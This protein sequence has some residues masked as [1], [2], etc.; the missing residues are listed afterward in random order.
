MSSLR[1]IR[2]C[3]AQDREVYLGSIDG[4]S[5]RFNSGQCTQF[6]YQ[7]LNTCGKVCARA[8]PCKA[9]Q[10]SGIVAHA[11]SP[12]LNVTREAN[13]V[14]CVCPG[15]DT[16]SRR[17]PASDADHPAHRGLCA[18]VAFWR[19]AARSATRRTVLRP[20]RAL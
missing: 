19:C 6:G 10:T 9:P 7:S 11:L 18:I 13:F 17:V 12:T 3:E 8:T 4:T 1:T 16:S 2:D 14:Y 15:R 20:G 5:V